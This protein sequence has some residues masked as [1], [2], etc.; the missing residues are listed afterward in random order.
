MLGVLMHSN[1]DVIKVGKQRW[2]CPWPCW[3]WNPYDYSENSWADSHPQNRRLFINMATRAAFWDVT[4][5]HVLLYGNFP[6]KL[7]L[8]FLERDLS[9][10]ALTI[11]DDKAVI[12]KKSSEADAARAL[13]SSRELW[14]RYL[15]ALIFSSLACWR[16]A[17]DIWKLIQKSELDK[18]EYHSGSLSA[19]VTSP[20][21][22][23]CLQPQAVLSP[24]H[25]ILCFF[26]YIL[27]C[28]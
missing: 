3:S 4:M 7:F 16:R 9:T 22:S 25:R 21:L 12:L 27:V 26:M 24:M 18:S 8:G 11:S 10:M 23:G 15:Y 1:Q 17:R 13:E 5:P 28:A 20:V 14:T 2:D 6:A 19:G